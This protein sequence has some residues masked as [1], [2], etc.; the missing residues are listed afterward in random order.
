MDEEKGNL[1]EEIHSHSWIIIIL[2]YFLFFAAGFNSAKSCELF[3]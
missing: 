1:Q 2:G 3:Q